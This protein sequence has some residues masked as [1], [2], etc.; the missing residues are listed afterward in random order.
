MI[1]RENPFM[2]GLRRA[3][4]IGAPKYTFREVVSVILAGLAYMLAL[5]VLTATILAIICLAGCAHNTACRAPEDVLSKKGVVLECSPGP[6]IDGEATKTCLV[7]RPA[8]GAVT[9]N[10]R[11]GNCRP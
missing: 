7:V 11:V 2:E 9:V 10:I 5:A 4:R 6:V 3:A 1:Q 8:G